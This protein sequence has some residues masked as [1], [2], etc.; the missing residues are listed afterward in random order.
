MSIAAGGLG[1]V[2]GGP[3]GAILGAIAG[4]A[5]HKI[6]NGLPD[7]DRNS[8]GDFHISFLILSAH[9]VKADGKT[10]SREISFVYNFLLHRFP[11]HAKDLF[12]AFQEILE[13]DVNIEEVC[14]Q[15]AEHLTEAEQQFII[16]FLY[17][18]SKADGHID[19]LELQE[20]RKIAHLLELHPFILKQIEAR[21]FRSSPKQDNQNELNEALAVFNLT[22][23]ASEQEIKKAYRDAIKQHHPDK[24]E[25]LGEEHKKIAE[26]YFKKIQDAYQTIKRYQQN[27]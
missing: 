5:V 8:S 22:E 19:D 17:D 4:R 7:L 10:D 26:E 11:S 12:D 16:S 13:Q 18:L 3:I 15:L 1:F 2:L 27:V 21:F 24:V 9:I 23:S 20:I 25:H 14:E 6:M